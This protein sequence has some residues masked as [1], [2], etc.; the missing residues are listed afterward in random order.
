KTEV[1]TDDDFIDE[2]LF[3]GKVWGLAHIAI[4]KCMLHRD[5]EFILLIKNYL[6][7]VRTRE[8]ELVRLQEVVVSTSQNIVKNTE[9][10]MIQLENPQK[11][12]GRG[13]PKAASHHNKIS[14]I[15]QYKKQ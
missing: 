12:V 14:R 4:N 11:V 10:S 7:R 13:R 3:Y 2:M 6:N 8:E 1:I 15:L 5:N 9:V